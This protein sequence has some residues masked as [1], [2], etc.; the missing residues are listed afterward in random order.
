[1]TDDEIKKI[2]GERAVE[3]LAQMDQANSE[4]SYTNIKGK[5]YAEVKEKI[6]A[7]RKVYPEGGITTKIIELDKDHCVAKAEIFNE[8]GA[9]LSSGHAQE[10][11]ATLKLKDSLVEV[12]ETSAIGRALSSLGF[13]IKGGLA[14]AETMQRVA[15]KDD[16]RNKLLICARCYQPINDATDKSGTTWKA[17]D[18]SRMTT[19]VFG[20]PYCLPCYAAV[21][22]QHI[23]AEV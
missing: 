12:A 18:I 22:N 6:K 20:V 7:F 5:D 21:K 15:D 17:E 19:S 16:V 10:N 1:M 13:G 23:K 3:V 4:I 11:M 8:L 9:L 14:P 2:V